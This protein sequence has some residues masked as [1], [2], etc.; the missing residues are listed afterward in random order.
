MAPLG[1]SV[2]ILGTFLWGVSHILVGF[3]A[4]FAFLHQFLV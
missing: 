3:S 1:L 4:S 2:L